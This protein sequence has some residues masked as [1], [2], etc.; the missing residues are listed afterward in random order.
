M[1]E[2][3]H[4]VAEVGMVVIDTVFRLRGK[5]VV[6]YVQ[7]QGQKG[8]RTGGIYTYIRRISSSLVSL[9]FFRRSR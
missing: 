3:Y 2:W 7:G 4:V 1:V 9:I 8:L 6:G 5:V